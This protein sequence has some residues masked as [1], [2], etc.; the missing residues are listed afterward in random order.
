MT[1][2]RALHFVFKVG[3]RTKT[4]Q[5][6][7]KILG[8]K[9]LR[10]EEFEEGCK[11][12]CNGPYDGRWS[13]SMVGFGPEEN[14]FV[15]EL[16]YNYGIGSYKLGNDFLGITILGK[17]ILDRAKAQNYP[18]TE[19]N[20][21]TVL[22]SPDGYKF[23]IE[24]KDP[25]KDADPVV[26]VALASSNLEKSIDYWTRL[27]G[28]KVYS[29]TDKTALLGYADDQCKLELHDIG[30]PVDHGTAFGRIAFSCPRSQLAG[31][32]A[33]VKAEKQKIIMPL[34]S[35]DTPGKATVEV[36]ILADP[37]GHEICFV[38]DEAFRELS[39]V[40]PKAEQLLSEAVDKDQSDE[41]FAK[42][43]L[44]KGSA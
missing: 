13:K 27:L 39:K 31:I 14:H 19:E 43:G 20:G 4:A 17:A 11:A 8:M 2:R 30:G 18:V 5:F 1:S 38:G 10:H 9:F 23:H 35:L 3:N 42:K 22:Q 24:N 41:W 25:D 16:T 26:K 34:V 33:S 15:V 7:Q 44:Q 12:S 28:M 40:D 32:E 37:D 21:K 29:K 36:V 6:Y